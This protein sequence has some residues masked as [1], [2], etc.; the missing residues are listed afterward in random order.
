MGSEAVKVPEAVIWTLHVLRSR[1]GFN[2]SLAK[3]IDVQYIT[4][5]M[6]SPHDAEATRRR[7][8]GQINYCVGIIT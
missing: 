1:I 3:H 2:K 8:H 6:Y 7:Y 5:V 4:V